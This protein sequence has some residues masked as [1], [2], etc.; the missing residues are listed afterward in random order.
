MHL[1]TAARVPPTPTSAPILMPSQPSGREN[2]AGLYTTSMPPA[3]TTTAGNSNNITT[4]LFKV[5]S[6]NTSAFFT[7]VCTLFI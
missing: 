1:F 7:Q 4:F 2:D 3:S 5:E 6:E